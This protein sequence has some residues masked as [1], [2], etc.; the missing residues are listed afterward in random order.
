MK[1]TTSKNPPSAGF[2]LIEIL[3]VIVIIAVMSAIAVPAYVRYLAHVRFQTKVR[4]VQD[5]FAYAREQAVTRDSTVTL[6]F[7]KGTAMFTVE[8]TPPSQLSDQPAAFNAGDIT[9]SSNGQTNNTKNVQL[10]PEQTVLQYTVSEGTNAPAKP[11]S[12]LQTGSNDLHFLSDGTVEGLDMT[13]AQ[14]DGRR[15]HLQ[16]MPSTGRLMLEPGVATE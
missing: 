6:R 9:Q 14:N 12:K 11:A 16:L 1:R 5:I 3:I 13:M 7:D 8:F 15:A 10:D 4:Q 2:T